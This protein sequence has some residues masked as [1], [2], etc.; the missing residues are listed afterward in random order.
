MGRRDGNLQDS[1][2]WTFLEGGVVRNKDVDRTLDG[3][4]Y[5][6]VSKVS[7]YEVGDAL[8]RG[9]RGREWLS[10]DGFCTQF[11]VSRS[12]R[13]IVAPPQ[14]NCQAARHARQLEVSSAYQPHFPP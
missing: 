2:R 11:G 9:T 7:R 14:N 4:Q 10:V 8:K 6:Y 3:L 5:G 1:R 12:G 13:K